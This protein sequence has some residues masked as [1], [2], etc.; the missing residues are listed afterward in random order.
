MVL[1]PIDKDLLMELEYETRFLVQLARIYGKTNLQCD[2]VIGLFD[3]LAAAI[4]ATAQDYTGDG[5]AL[6]DTGYTQAQIQA[7]L[8]S[9]P[10]PPDSYLEEA[11]D[12]RTEIGDSEVL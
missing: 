7:T 11:Y 12:A 6:T 9:F 10:P 5:D 3:R 8:R 1:I 4:K 2:I